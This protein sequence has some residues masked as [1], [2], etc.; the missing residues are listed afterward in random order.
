MYK[1]A[2]EKTLKK[3]IDPSPLSVVDCNKYSPNV[4][5]LPLHIR[6][7]HYKSSL[8]D[9]TSHHPVAMPLSESLKTKVKI[10]FA[11]NAIARKK[12]GLD[13]NPAEY[14]FHNKI[15]TF[16][17]TGILGGLHAA[18][19]PVATKL[20]DSVA[21]D[22]H[23]VRTLI[24]KRL[25]KRIKSKGVR[26]IDL[27]CG[28][29]ISTR[30]IQAEFQEAQVIVGVDTSPEMISMAKFLNHHRRQIDEVRVFFQKMVESVLESF[31][32]GDADVASDFSQKRLE[33]LYARGNAERTN[34][35]PQSFDL[36]TIM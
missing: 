22:G 18:M 12:C 10:P 11:R 17:N 1:N 32:F 35:P 7:Q 29:G 14:W 26:I 13:E 30:A 27:C 24:A 19:A 15:H 36:A 33:A 5:S 4:P 25:C 28:V 23:S 9:T 16:G 21:Y 2:I 6:Q 31:D 34:F 20:I 3:K 8:S